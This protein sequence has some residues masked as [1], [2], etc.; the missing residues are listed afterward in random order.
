MTEKVKHGYFLDKTVKWMTLK[1]AWYLYLLVLG[2]F[3]ISNVFTRNGLFTSLGTN[4]MT[5]IALFLI[6]ITSN[7][8]LRESTENEAKAF[9]ES[10]KEVT[11]ELT[12]VSEATMKSSEA[13]SRV[14]NGIIAVA[15]KTTELVNI[16]QAKENERISLLRPKIFVSIFIDSWGLLG[17]T[18]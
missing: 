15:G 10:I 6:M 12:K 1:R 11:S 16:E 9:I 13:I 2:A 18:Q 8:V 17:Q 7:Q 4:I 5:I 14:E 3:I